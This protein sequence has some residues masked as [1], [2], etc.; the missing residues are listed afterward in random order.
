M[1][2]E[3]VKNSSVC[4][5]GRERGHVTR[6]TIDFGTKNTKERGHGKSADGM[7]SLAAARAS[8]V[9]CSVLGSRRPGPLAPV[10][11]RNEHPSVTSREPKGRPSAGREPRVGLGHTRDTQ[12]LQ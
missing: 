10:H 7:R 4:L 2:V 1:W 12:C 8:R 5:S 3:G 11:A 6:G 9:R